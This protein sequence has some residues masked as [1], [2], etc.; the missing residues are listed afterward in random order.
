MMSPQH[1]HTYELIALVASRF[2]KKE[3]NPTKEKAQNTSS[4]PESRSLF[5]C[6]ARPPSCSLRCSI[7]AAVKLIVHSR[8]LPLSDSTVGTGSALARWGRRGLCSR[9]WCSTVCRALA[10]LILHRRC[11]RLD[12]AYHEHASKEDLS[13]NVIRL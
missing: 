11:R 10:C 6:P 7:A 5:L 2:S 9:G 12:G 4:S 13:S 8:V 1:T 3:K